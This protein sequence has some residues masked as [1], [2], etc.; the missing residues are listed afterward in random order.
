MKVTKLN[1]SEYRITLHGHSF[2]LAKLSGCKDWTLWN[3]AKQADINR[4]QTKSGMLELMRHWSPEH[5]EAQAQQ[6]SYI[7]A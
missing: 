6:E 7:Y 1:R 5:T 4:A 3:D 2:T